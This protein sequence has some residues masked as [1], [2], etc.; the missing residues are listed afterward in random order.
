[1]K[2]FGMKMIRYSLDHPRTV[3]AVVAAVTVSLALAAALPSIWPR[4]FPWL[5]AVKVDTDPENML[6][7]DE[8]ARVFHHDMKKLFSLHDMIVLGVVNEKDPEGVFNPESLAR[9]YEL[10]EFA[11]TLQWPDPKDPSRQ[12][13]VVEVDLIA[14]STVD[15]I[16]PGGPGVVKFEWLM[17]KPPKTRAEA[18]EIR[19]RA[20]RIPFLNGT[21]VSEDGKAICLYLPL[22]AKDL[23]YKVSKR[24]KQKIAGFKGEDRFF[25]TGLPVAEDTFGVEMFVQMAISGPL[26]MLT[27]FLL[28]WYFFRKISLILS[29][30]AV[31]L[32]SVVC[33][34]S[35]LIISGKTIHI[36]SSMIPV[37]LMPIAVLDSVHIL[38]M[39][40]DR[41]QKLRDRRETMMSVMDSLFN[42]MLYTSLTTVAGF[43]S[44]ALTPIPPVQVFGLFCAFGISLAWVLTMTFI[45]A[46]VAFIPEKFLTHFGLSAAEEVPQT[47]LAR[48]L[49]WVGDATRRGANVIILGMLV[50][51]CVA[52]YGIHKIRVNDNPTKWFTKSHPIRV[53][54]AVLNRHFGGTYMAYLALEA[55]GKDKSLSAYVEGFRKRLAAQAARLAA[56]N[57]QSASVFGQLGEEASRRAATAGGIDKLLDRLAAFADAQADA[58]E[59]DDTADAWDDAGTFVAREKQ[60]GEVFKQPAVLNYML[61]LQEHLKKSGI[62]GKSNS[63]ADIVRTV[64]R[65]L[66]QSDPAHFT[67]PKSAEAV[68]QCLMTYQNSHR[69]QDIWHFVTPDYRQTSLWL[70]LHSGDNV[71]M[72]AV[73]QAVDRFFKENPPPV[74]IQ[75]KWFGLTYINV[76]WQEKMVWG[77]LFSFLG[78]YLV[79]FLMML[80]LFRSLLWGILSM[81]PLTV[82]IGLIYG[83]IGLIGKDYDMP[84]AVLSALSLGL[85]VDFAIHFLEQARVMRAKYGSWA[86]AAGPVFGEPA[87][88]ISRNVIVIAVGFLPLVPTPL[89]PYR[90]VGVFLAAIMAVA[91]I[92]T[93]LIL[94]ALVTK[95]EK[96]L[97]PAKQPARP[98]CSCAICL[99]AGLASVALVAV[100]VHQFFGTE[101]NRLS[102]FGVVAV[103]LLLLSCWGLSR[104]KTCRVPEGRRDQDMNEKDGT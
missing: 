21:L 1:M 25:I 76:V 61:R 5:N 38:S 69:P 48:G 33:T 98:S 31:T 37:F 13:G 15:S 45:P 97:F 81:I 103:P 51:A 18:V 62:V 84:V 99:A 4:S 58:A 83:A 73:T 44:L 14:P 68:A 78:S 59:D 24:L 92:T 40:F 54:D 10:A 23:S 39:F 79:V 56:D 8:A 27:I 11:K 35:L 50:V 102:V 57:P 17:A 74:P 85:A 87:R 75:H 32:V 16:E 104:R 22:T 26:A 7:K 53:A 20:A 42:P 94:P 90:T 9:I 82:T 52:V 36:M 67:I 3:F 71:D 86:R 101:W 60:R 6:S 66:F 65:E 77:M 2:R 30:L 46:F 70:Q 49:A 43:A 91:G 28:M 41:Y 89:I 19:R 72:V 80:A 93:L 47:A 95:L 64:H 100:N 34:M 96:V 29:P 12:V 63:L 55:T 88:A